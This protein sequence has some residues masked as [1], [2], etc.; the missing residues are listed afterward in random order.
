MPIRYISNKVYWGLKFY[1]CFLLEILKKKERTLIF[2][3]NILDAYVIGYNRK[4]L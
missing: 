1:L 3:Q 4:K 2:K